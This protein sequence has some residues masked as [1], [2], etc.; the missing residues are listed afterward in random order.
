MERIELDN[1]LPAVF[2]GRDNIISDLWLGKLC[3]EKGKSYLIEA[4]SGT[5]KSSLCS[6]IYGYRK[7]YEGLISFDDADIKN[8]SG[9]TWTEIRQKNLGMMFQELRLFPELTAGENVILKNNLTHFRDEAQIRKWFSMLGIEDKW[10]EPVGRMS[11]GQQQR[12]AFIRMLCQPSDFLF[13]DEPVSHLDD[14]NGKIMAKI[15]Y[16]EIRERGVGVIVT[17]IGRRLEMNYNAEIKL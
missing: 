12:V 1:V 4:A 3:F 5:G 10:A 6:F 8:F 2:S 17:S 9:S 16:D 13:M 14:A 15:L 11:F 7:D